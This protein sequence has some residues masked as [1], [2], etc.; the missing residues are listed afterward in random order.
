MLYLA[1]LMYLTTINNICGIFMWVRSWNPL[2]IAFDWEA[3]GN[4]QKVMHCANYD[5]GCSEIRQHV[6]FT[7][8][9]CCKLLQIALHLADPVPFI[10]L[11]LLLP[12]CNVRRQLLPR[13]EHCFTLRLCDEALSSGD[14]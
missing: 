5:Q 10:C 8:M 9:M 14:V 13:V 11:L 3:V 7:T 1:V 2:A 6:L 12:I 4:R